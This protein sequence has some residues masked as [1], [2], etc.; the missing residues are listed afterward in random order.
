MK[1]KNCGAPLDEGALFC[2]RC[3]TAVPKAPEPAP[4]RIVKK[5]KKNGVLSGITDWVADRA[6]RIGKWCADVFDKVRNWLGGLKDSKL[7]QNRRLLMLTGAGAALLL[8]LII[9]IASAASCKKTEKYKTPEELTA[10][11]IDAL[12][13]GDGER[14]YKMSKLSHKVLGE[15]TE[16]FG[17]GD[18]P[19]AVMQGYY[20]RMAEEV[21]EKRAA[22]EDTDGALTGQTET[23]IITDTSI[24]ET[25]RAL[26]LEA[27][28]Y[29]E[30]TGPLLEDD[31]FVANV[32]IVAVELDGE[33]KLLVVYLY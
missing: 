21:K 12:D 26:G 32:R 11:V 28:Q 18:T 5:K 10:A 4:K 9:I 14:L 2:R 17:E 23:N 3:G 6:G 25:N 8:V 29:A 31:A 15:H 20:Q 33:W 7:L 27:A 1:C 30:I 22:I 16:L 13:A 19:E 24:Y